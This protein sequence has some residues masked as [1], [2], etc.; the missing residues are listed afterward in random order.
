[1]HNTTVVSGKPFRKGVF[2][3]IF[4]ALSLFGLLPIF[5]P[6]IIYLLKFEQS[7]AVKATSVI[8]ANE[9]ICGAIK[10]LYKKERPV[11]MPAKNLFQLYMARG[12][13][14]VHTARITVFAIIAGMLAKNVAVAAV[15]AVLVVAVAYSRIYL[16][17]H[18]WADVLGGFAIGAVS[19]LIGAAWVVA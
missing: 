17:K 8:L 13:P 5:V 3:A 10:L 2:H 9:V 16:R 4:S 14:S 1:M 6:L 15:C 7:V 12:F 19:G 11:P 18:D